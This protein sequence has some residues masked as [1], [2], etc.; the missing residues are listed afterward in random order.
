MA[1]ADALAREIAAGKRKAGDRLPPQRIF[2]YDNGIAT[3][4]ASRVYAELLRRGLVTG[5]VGRGTFVAGNQT[6]GKLADRDIHDSRIDLEFNFP[7]LPSQSEMIAKSL[8]G[9]QRADALEAALRPVG[10][11][12]LAAASE[13]AAAFL[14][15]GSWRPAPDAF[16]LTGSG[17]QSIAA[18]ISALTP[19]G[20]RIAVEAVT[21]PMIKS[22]AGRLG[23]SLVPIPMDAGGMDPEALDMAQQKGSLSAI[24]LQPVLQ[25]PLGISQPQSR[26][27]EI[28]A[29]AEKHGLMIIEDHVYGFLA[30]DEP[31]AMLAPERCIVVDS[32]SKRIAPGLAL[33]FLCAPQKHRDRLAT[34]VRAGAWP[35]SGYGLEA[36]MRVM[37][38]GTA[39]AITAEKRRDA[40]MRQELAATC[41]AECEIKADPRAYH[42]WLIL[43]EGW[44]S[45]AFTTAAAR[46]GI[47]VTPSSAFAV[48]PGHA[49]NAVRL[50]L[51]LPQLDQLRYALT[52]LASLL[53][54]RPEEAEMAE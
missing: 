26:R 12:K 40:R 8:A 7:I 36:G 51:A 20:G 33:G 18:A 29:V 35:V 6:G 19:V 49:P 42:L 24:Y 1:L 3:S 48:A 46:R 44:R 2:A 10:A 43:P 17:R 30:D 5:E 37:N 32:L 52:Q 53:C 25:N 27:K 38:D 31:L 14:A 15:R 23:V 45:E 34:T 47:A 54:L 11:V 9:L 21:Y 39:M 16:V 28:I 50:A 41:L 13:A 4:T 22:L